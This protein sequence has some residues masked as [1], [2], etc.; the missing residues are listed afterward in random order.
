[1]ES[2]CGYYNGANFLACGAGKFFSGNQCL[3][4]KPV[5]CSAHCG[6][7]DCAVADTCLIPKG[8]GFASCDSSSVYVHA[9]TACKKKCANSIEKIDV[10]ACY[11]LKD[12]AAEVC[13]S[14]AYYFKDACSTDDATAIPKTCDQA[15]IG[16]AVKPAEICV[17]DGQDLCS[18]TDYLYK[19][20][21]KV[22]LVCIQDCTESPFRLDRAACVN[23]GSVCPVGSFFYEGTCR[24]DQPP[25]CVA[26]DFL[27]TTCVFNGDQ[28]CI[29][30]MKFENGACG[31]L[32]K[33]LTGGGVA[34]IAIAVGITAAV[35]VVLA[36]CLA[37]RGK[38]ALAKPEKVVDLRMVD[39]EAVN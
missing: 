15:E 3:T 25:T 31:V 10:N 38:K 8:Q 18:P 27:D 39:D 35:A 14:G 1:M 13:A 17:V 32:K 20:S 22:K 26:S 19:R 29:K 12:G 16:K 30:G 23:N 7:K 21:E 33:T 36:C 11:Y 37:P 5:L 28:L 9:S 2:E 4:K 34:G 24:N 6:Y